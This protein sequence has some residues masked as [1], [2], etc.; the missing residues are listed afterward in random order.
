M[1]LRRVT[2]GLNWFWLLVLSATG[3]SSAPA[4][5][6]TQ[7]T[8]AYQFRG[9]RAGVSVG[10]DPYF[11]VE[12]TQLAFRGGESFPENGVLPVQVSIQNGNR[13]EIKFDPRD[14]RL[15]R[16]DSRVEF[17]IS[18]SEAFSLARLSVG[19]WAAVPILGPSSVAVRN[20]PR[21][22]DL[23]SR[24]LREGSLAPGNSTSGFVYF[25]I[26]PEERDLAG[27]L[28]VVV[29]KT[30]GGLDLIYEIPIEGRR[31]IPVPANP[32]PA[33]ASQAST[34]PTSS[35]RSPQTP[36]RIE[37]AGGGVIIRSPSQ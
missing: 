37:G 25:R 14:F 19:W 17:P 27:S 15:V 31:D 36:T 28:V 10:V 7:P 13:E 4:V 30:V 3:C 11:T 34:P 35:G 22:K 24:E 5:I 23:E 32:V 20:E 8:E 12:R 21:Q 16:R 6:P 9:M 29:L 1:R 18:A 2:K 26:A 33:S